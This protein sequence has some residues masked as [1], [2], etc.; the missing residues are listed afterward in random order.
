MELTEEEKKKFKE[1]LKEM[2]FDNDDPPAL[3]KRLNDEAK[4][5]REARE[6]SD[7]II[8][9][10]EKNLKV[11]SDEKADRDKKETDR[12]AEEEKKKK[13]QADEN[14]TAQELIKE[15]EGRFETRLAEQQAIH[16]KEI[17]DRD[18]AV[19]AR[20]QRLVKTL[21]RQIAGEKGLIDLDLVDTLDLKGIKVE[22]GEPD[23]TAIEELLTKHAEAKPRLYDVTN[24]QQQQQEQQP[25]YGRQT[26]RPDISGSTP[27]KGGIDYAKL[28]DAAFDQAERELRAQRV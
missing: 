9:D 4:T 21:V 1:Y 23:Q 16:T 14:K 26:T 28:D 20:D 7:K 24:R 22:D 8:K 11:L 12:L 25:G 3:I 19:N 17:K 13:S 5:S 15:A 6:A 10:L 27:P 2:G 18:K